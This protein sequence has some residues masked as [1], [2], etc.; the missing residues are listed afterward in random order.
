[1]DLI[2]ELRRSDLL[3]ISTSGKYEVDPPLVRSGSFAVKDRR[4]SK[5]PGLAW[6]MTP[7]DFGLP[8]MPI[9]VTI[10]GEPAGQDA[11]GRPLVRL[12]IDED[13]NFAVPGR[14]VTVE[15][16]KGALTLA[17][18]PAADGQG[19]AFESVGQDDELLV[20]VRARLF[21]GLGRR[22]VVRVAAPRVEGTARRTAEAASP[23]G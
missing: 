20:T 3:T 8:D 23:S 17:L 6:E 10:R 22:A 11:S 12:T 2:E 7:S 1:M 9:S 19:V 15:H 14:R 21:L 16:V 4:V 18:S 5:P 13:V